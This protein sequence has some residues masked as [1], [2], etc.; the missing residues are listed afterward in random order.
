MSSHDEKPQ[1]FEEAADEVEQEDDGLRDPIENGETDEDVATVR[2]WMSEAQEDEERERETVPSHIKNGMKVLGHVAGFT[3]SVKDLKTV[4]TATTEWEREH[5]A[6][7][8]IDFEPLSEEQILAAVE[9]CVK[10]KLIEL[11][12][13]ADSETDLYLPT[14]RGMEK[15]GFKGWNAGLTES[16]G[17]WL[18]ERG[19]EHGRT[20]AHI[21]SAV[22]RSVRIDKRYLKQVQ[23]D[24]GLE[25]V[26]GLAQYTRAYELWSLWRMRK[27][28]RGDSFRYLF[29]VQTAERKHY[30]AAFLYPK[31]EV[32]GRA[33]LLEVFDRPLED[34]VAVEEIE[35]ILSVWSKRS[36]V[37]SVSC[38]VSEENALT[39]QEIVRDL[40]AQ[41]KIY[42]IKIPEGADAR[43]MA[44]AAPLPSLP[45][46]MTAADRTLQRRIIKC[47]GKA[48][49]AS[50]AGI[51]GVLGVRDRRVASLLADAV[52]GKPVDGKPV[53]D[54]PV[55]CSKNAIEGVDIYWLTDKGREEVGYPPKTKRVTVRHARFDKERLRLAAL[56]KRGFSRHTVELVGSVE[57]EDLPALLLRPEDQTALPVAVV[58]ALEIRGR[59]DLEHLV[60][61][62]AQDREVSRTIIYAV[63][64]LAEV[65]KDIAEAHDRVTIRSLLSEQEEARRKA[66]EKR[67]KIEANR[68][69]DLARRE[70]L[71]QKVK[72]E[73]EEIRRADAA[74]AKKATAKKAAAKRAAIR[75][76]VAKET[77]TPPNPKPP[78]ERSPYRSEKHR[79]K[80]VPGMRPVG[81]A[82]WKEFDECMQLCIKQKKMQAPSANSMS[83]RLIVDLA[84]W[85]VEQGWKFDQER[86]VRYLSIHDCGLTEGTFKSYLKLLYDTGLWEALQQIMDGHEPHRKLKWWLIDPSNYKRTLSGREARE[87]RQREDQS[88][89]SGSERPRVEIVKIE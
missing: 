54:K 61:K 88:D 39:V 9:W 64:A 26:G 44:A 11:D 53:E 20:L 36:T 22:N 47:I 14:Y 56:L 4:F 29:E 24:E 51:A 73:K 2:D 15:A 43:A 58:M 42:V 46:E 5:G 21:V 67:R 40:K 32:T 16:R 86:P 65:L 8:P 89:V 63:P 25:V 48:R 37:Y 18:L 35:K 31:A 62:H 87:Q 79:P 75:K 81:A 82:A 78:Q 12:T 13:E 76:A 19:G 33:V 10:E 80:N 68:V 85:L 49:F 83:M 17:G 55:K 28:G 69:S 74:A 7:D 38:Y 27:Q 66:S 52:Q 3:A 70:A 41:S 72:Q 60:Q 50:V 45:D 1:L 6:V 57:T 71:A 23:L 34:E 30:P 77:H 59:V 84:V